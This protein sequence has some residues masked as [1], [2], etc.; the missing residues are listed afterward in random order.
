MAQWGSVPAH[1]LQKLKVDGFLRLKISEVAQQSVR[2]TCDAAYEFFKSP[3]SEKI[4]NRLPEDTGYR[5]F[6]IEYSRSPA[7]PDAVESFTANARIQAATSELPSP[8][9]KIL[10]NK[11]LATF[12]I[13]E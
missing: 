4:L 11:A 12:H 1:L 5:P 2:D 13:L 3:L 10:W 6:G 7:N 9:A 8:K